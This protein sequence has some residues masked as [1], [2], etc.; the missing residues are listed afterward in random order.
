MQSK[1]YIGHLDGD[2]I[3]TLS[4]HLQG[5]ADLA[6]QFG[7]P[8]GIG[9]EAQIMGKG[10]DIGKET[11][12]FQDYILGKRK[13]RV[14]HSTAGAK[15]L[16]E[17]KKEYG[18]LAVLGAFCIAGHHC[19]LMNLGTKFDEAGDGTLWGRM[20]KLIPHLQNEIDL[21]GEDAIDLTNLKKYGGKPIDIMLLTRMLYSCLVDADFLDT[22]NFM[23][24]DR[25][26]RGEF[27]SLDVLHERFEK[28]LKERGYRTPKNELNQKRYEILSCCERKG[29]G[30]AGLYSL[31]VPTG[32]GKTISSMAFALQ[33]A[34][35]HH[36]VRIIYVIPYLSIIDQTA[37]I[38]KDFFG[39]EAV[40]ESHSQIN[41]E[42][43][44]E[45]LPKE[46][47]LLAEKMKLA[48][49]NWDAPIIIT[50]NEQFWESLYGNRVSK[51]R[52]LHNIANSVIIFDEAQ[53]LPVDFLRPCLYA[54]QDLVQYYGCT[55]VLCSATQPALDGY[56][57]VKPNEIMENIPELYNF[58]SRVSFKVD[59]LKD[60]D[61]I[62]AALNELQQV[63][64][65]ASTK[66]EAEE[67]FQRVNKED[68][69]YLSTNLCPAHRKKVIAEIKERLQKGLPCRVVSTSII[70][71]GVDIDFPTVYLEYTGLDALIQGAGRCNREGKQNRENSIAHV[72]WTEKSWESRFMGKEKEVTYTVIKNYGEKNMTSPAAIG[73]YFR[74]WYESNEG[75]LDYKEIED[76]SQKYAFSD[77]GKKFHLIADSTKSIFIPYDDHGRE[78][79]QL[80][81]AGCR[82]R[83]LMR[84]AGQYMVNVRYT[85]SPHTVS[86]FWKLYE[87]GKIVMYP[88]DEELAYLAAESAYDSTM[89]LKI[90][91]EEGVSILW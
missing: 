4:S 55:A 45:N 38:F 76:L 43:N 88:N 33:Q 67:I 39:K 1:D 18:L 12:D 21:I 79:H 23:T 69:Y 80:L 5:V 89:G 29:Q 8:I 84:E 82:T 81:M 41:Y 58:F 24:P 62:A 72:F 54:L 34:V 65:V 7:A 59:R 71:V 56:L 77:I 36:K 87:T 47:A 64:C 13:R 2:R 20:K 75:N 32:G 35:T 37:H 17:H 61:E 30:P 70:S 85:T 11:T 31:T 16:W 60:Y 46:K 6:F 53:M 91:S 25:V 52:K 86:D 9:Q 49:E 66:R 50:T 15:Y 10:H 73:E 74:L 42:S 14:D 3:Q 83:S 90:D 40:L 44:E 63:L 22:E 68:S 28:A 19:G 48:T 51:C 78:I 27:P 26:K 57:T